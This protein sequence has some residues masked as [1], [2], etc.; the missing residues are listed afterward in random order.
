MV[1]ITIDRDNEPSPSQL[2]SFPAMAR[3]K[4]VAVWSVGTLTNYRQLHGAATCDPVNAKCVQFVV[5]TVFHAYDSMLH[6]SS[7]C[8]VMI[9]QH[10]RRWTPI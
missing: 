10:S 1:D 3:V 8:K 5:N 2:S 7:S 9:Q 6:S 4:S